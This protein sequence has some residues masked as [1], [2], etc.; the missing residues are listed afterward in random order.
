MVSRIANGIAMKTSETLICQ[1]SI[2]HDLSLVGKKALLV[3]KTSSE[4]SAIFPICTKPVK[5][6][7]VRGVP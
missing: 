6:I 4:T 7:T 5:K 2:N 1:K 3:G